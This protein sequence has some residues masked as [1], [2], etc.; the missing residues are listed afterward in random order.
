VKP[1]RFTRFVSAEEPRP[2]TMHPLPRRRLLIPLLRASASPLRD[3]SSTVRAIDRSF[4]DND[5]LSCAIDQPFQDS[6][7]FFQ[8][9]DHASIVISEP[10]IDNDQ[11]LLVISQRFIDNDQ[12][13]FVIS[14]RCIVISERCIVISEPC[15]VISQPFRDNDQAPIVSSSVFIVISKRLCRITF[16]FRRVPLRLCRMTKGLRPTEAAQSGADEPR[17]TDDPGKIVPARRA[18]IASAHARDGGPD[19]AAE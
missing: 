16:L 17:Q 18:K 9:N 10:P 1:S 5:Q 8:D 13:L 2:T 12:L 6:T 15:I 19:P 11:P 14:E 7:P 3:Q 4:P